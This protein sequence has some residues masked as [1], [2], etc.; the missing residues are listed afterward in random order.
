MT[1]VTYKMLTMCMVQDGDKVLLINR[2]SKLGFPGYIA[3]GGKVDFPESI[4]D[5]AMREVQ[6]ETGLIVKDIVYKGLDEFCEPNEGL[7]YMVFNYL[8]TSFE[9]E[10]IQNPPEGELLWVDINE[11]LELPMQ[12]WFKRRFPLFFEPGTFELSFVWDGKQDKTL[13]ET[14]KNYNQAEIIGNSR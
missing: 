11:A 10:L 14:V 7:R 2:P 13:K 12:D 9:G 3:P 8:A 6:E 4:V 5:A 1:N